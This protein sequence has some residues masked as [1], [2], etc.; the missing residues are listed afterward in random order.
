MKIVKQRDELDCGVC[1]LASVIKHY[2]GNVPLEVIRLDAKTNN[3]GTSALNLILAAQKYGLDGS[4]LEL[5]SLKSIKKLPAIAHLKLKNGL[6][7]YVVI[8]K[9]TKDKVV[10]MDPGKGKV[11]KT[12]VFL[13]YFCFF[14]F[15]NKILYVN[16]MTIAPTKIII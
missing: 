3:S 14:L 16:N 7:H 10:V 12:K 15:L 8:Y 2:K 6:N 4:G 5:E 1:C 9:I 11:V 13:I